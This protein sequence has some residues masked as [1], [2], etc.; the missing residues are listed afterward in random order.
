MRT[1]IQEVFGFWIPL[2]GF[3]IPLPGFWIPLPRFWISKLIKDRILDNL[4][5]GDIKPPLVQC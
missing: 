3:W 4:T 1:V 2:P 5:W